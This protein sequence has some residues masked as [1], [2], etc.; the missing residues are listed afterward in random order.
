MG[1]CDEC[2]AWRRLLAP[3]STDYYVAFSRSRIF[4][5]LDPCPYSS[6]SGEN[7]STNFFTFVLRRNASA[8]H[9]SRTMGLI[10]SNSSRIRVPTRARYWSAAS[11]SDTSCFITLRTTRVVVGAQA[12]S[13]DM[14]ITLLSTR[15]RR[16][17]LLFRVSC[18]EAA[19][20]T[21]ALAVMWRR[22]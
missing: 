16:A 5:V 7:C 4:H 19:L 14:R 13:R 21:L 3:S 9:C 10:F 12:F 17:R 1:H 18:D 2:S 22:G 11:R 15:L 20:T 6:I 8:R